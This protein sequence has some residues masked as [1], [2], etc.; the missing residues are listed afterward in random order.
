MD[1]IKTVL[2][3][4]GW[5]VTVVFLFA[6]WFLPMAIL[7]AALTPHEASFSTF[8]FLG[9]VVSS[10]FLGFMTW[11]L[12]RRWKLYRAGKVFDKYV[13]GKVNR[14]HAF[15]QTARFAELATQPHRK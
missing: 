1:F 4:F 12:W 15:R 7:G 13:G 9:M 6:M 5:V 14:D 8:D 2:D 3:I 11:C 10:M